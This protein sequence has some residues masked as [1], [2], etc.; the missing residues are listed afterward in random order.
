[1]SSKIIANGQTILT[2][3][4]DD[5]QT[6]TKECGQIP[7]ARAKVKRALRAFVRY[8][9]RFTGFVHIAAIL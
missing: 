3:F 7:K 4:I 6:S 9:L 8:L 5:S 1:L 2:S